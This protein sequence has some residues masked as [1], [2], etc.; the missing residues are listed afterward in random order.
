MNLTEQASASTGAA[1]AS[2][3]GSAAGDKQKK[4]VSD[5]A[6][7]SFAVY[8]VRGKKEDAKVEV[9]AGASDA[10][11]DENG[12]VQ[13][14][15]SSVPFHAKSFAKRYPADGAGILAL[16]GHRDAMEELAYW[17]AYAREQN[18]QFAYVTYNVAVGFIN[19]LLVD[20]QRLKENPNTGFL[21]MRRTMSSLQDEIHE[22]FYQ[23]VKEER[24]NADVN[25]ARVSQIATRP[26][27]FDR[28]L[29]EDKDLKQLAVV[30][31]PV[32]DDPETP[33]KIRQLAYIRPGATVLDVRQGVETVDLL[34]PNWVTD[35]KVAK[36][37]RKASAG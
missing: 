37:F 33:G 7:T 31:I 6:L 18:A 24:G 36:K 29:E 9:L 12:R 2:A 13:L 22:K 30:V 1:A 11:I 32:A 19:P 26:D 35:E 4:V 14:L 5:I 28:L 27:L 3:D 25:M 15:A 8:R 34:L 10:R 23:Y 21:N 17:R 16:Y 20:R